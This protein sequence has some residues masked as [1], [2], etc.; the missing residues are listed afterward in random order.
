MLT[1]RMCEAREDVGEDRGYEF[2][3]SALRGGFE[4]W[5]QLS[6]FDWILKEKCIISEMVEL[7]QRADVDVNVI[8]GLD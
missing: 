3:G 4:T 7:L 5:G 8:D 6:R 1:S 2:C